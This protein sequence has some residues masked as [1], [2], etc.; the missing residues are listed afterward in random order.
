MTIWADAAHI[1]QAARLFLDNVKNSSPNLATRFL[2]QTGPMLLTMPLPRYF[3]T[4]SWWWVAYWSKSR[5]GTVVRI[6]GPELSGL[7]REPFPGTDGWQGSD[8]GHQ[9]A[10]PLGIELKHAESAV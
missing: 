10:V 1:L 6:P 8:H 4:P 3:S 9:V 7:G 2:A 5:P